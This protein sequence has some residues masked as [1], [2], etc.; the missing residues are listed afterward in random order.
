MFYYLEC[1]TKWGILGISG[2]TLPSSVASSL[3]LKVQLQTIIHSL[4]TLSGVNF[5]YLVRT[6]NTNVHALSHTCTQKHTLAHLV[7]CFQRQGKQGEHAKPHT[8]KPHLYG[9][10]EASCFSA[11]FLPQ[12]FCHTITNHYLLFIACLLLQ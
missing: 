5:V 4:L 11:R 1:A 9:N 8:E 6:A 2:D 12:V 7:H 10:P 3:I